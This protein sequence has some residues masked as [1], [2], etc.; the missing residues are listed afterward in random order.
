M[1]EGVEK[2]FFDLG[3]MPLLARTIRVFQEH[4]RVAEIVLVVSSRLKERIKNE[5]LEEYGFSKVK[6]TERGGP[7]RQDSV[8][9]GLQAFSTRPETVLIHDGDRPLV[10]PGTIDRVIDGARAGGAVAAIRPRDTVKVVDAR[11]IIIETPD[12]ALLRQAQTPQGFPFSDILAA[13]ERAEK[14]NWEVT[15]DASLIERSGGRVVAVEGGYENIKVTTPG[16]LAVAE[17]IAG[18]RR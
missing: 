5:I 8:Y 6:R 17:A 11:N 18:S 15:D 10:D 4:P 9:I 13:H 12:R 3:G 1:G 2:L 16:D 7:R 14:E